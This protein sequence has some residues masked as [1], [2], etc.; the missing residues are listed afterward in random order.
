MYLLSWQERA[1]YSLCSVCHYRRRRPFRRPQATGPLLLEL[2]MKVEFALFAIHL[3]LDRRLQPGEY[4]A[5]DYG[6][7]NGEFR[8]V[9]R[10]R[11]WLRKRGLNCRSGIW[12]LQPSTRSSRA[13]RAACGP[14][15]VI[16]FASTLSPP[17]VTIKAATARG[18]PSRA[19]RPL[20]KRW[21][22]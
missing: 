22:L 10:G 19:L 3:D 12:I 9:L 16:E 17:S 15:N 20:V 1:R 13:A 21:C 14:S 11:R 6:A 18:R 2:E 8:R 5:Q 7:S 4:G